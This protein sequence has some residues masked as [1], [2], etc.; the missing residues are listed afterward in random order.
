MT[1]RIGSGK[2]SA[3]VIVSAGSISSREGTFVL[4]CLRGTACCTFR[5]LLGGSLSSNS[6]M[7][8]KFLE[9]KRGLS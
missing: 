9:Q 3:V 5:D 6:R 2:V 4:V 7:L 8:Q 1:I